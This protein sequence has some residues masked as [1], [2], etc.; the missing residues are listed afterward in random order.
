MNN[1]YPLG[2]YGR[3]TRAAPDAQHRV[4]CMGK[5]V[6]ISKIGGVLQTVSFNTGRDDPEDIE[7]VN[8]ADCE[9][10]TPDELVSMYLVE[11]ASA[12]VNAE[13]GNYWEAE[14]D[15]LEAEVE[16]LRY[17][18]MLGASAVEDA[19]DALN[20]WNMQKPDSDSHF[21]ILVSY[22]LSESLGW[23]NANEC[24]SEVER[25]RWP[26]ESAAEPAPA[27]MCDCGNYAIEPGYRVCDSCRFAREMYPWNHEEEPPDEIE[28]TA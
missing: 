22:R 15:A 23:H 1:D 21:M 5:I 12:R 18:A 24:W 20:L 26:D 17:W 25:Y 3:I 11:E 9:I 7:T 16:H 4:G 13:R 14:H 10:I 27:E 28:A 19:R 2:L 6:G 8:C